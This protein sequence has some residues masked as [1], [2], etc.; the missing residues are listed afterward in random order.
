MNTA[1]SRM[2]CHPIFTGMGQVLVRP[3]GP[4]DAAMMQAF[5]ASLSG[6]S[7][8]FRFFQPL[9]QLPPSRLARLVNVDHRTH[10]AIVGVAQTQGKDCIVGEARYCTGDDAGS[11]RI[12]IVI[13][14]EWQRRGLGAGLLGI[15]ERIAVANAI[16]RLSGETFPFNDRFVSFARASGFEI[17]PDPTRRFLRFEKDIG[18][19]RAALFRPSASQ[20]NG[21]RQFTC[22]AAIR[23]VHK[24]AVFFFRPTELCRVVDMPR[25]GSASSQHKP[26]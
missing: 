4:G 18:G 5:V 1:D 20:V 11:A 26:P 3:M 15:L 24:L 25:A 14:D 16:T 17:W 10:I 8:Y 21:R 12:A 6:A 23:S 2:F 7:R 9:M 13:A 22:W 19:R